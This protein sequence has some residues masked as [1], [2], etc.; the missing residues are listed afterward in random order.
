MTSGTGD[1]KKKVK[2]A[3]TTARSMAHVKIPRPP[4]DRENINLARWGPPDL[5]RGG[6]GDWRSD[7]LTNG[8]TPRRRRTA[9]AGGA[10][11]NARHHCEPL[12]ASHDEA[13]TR[14]RRLDLQAPGH[15]GAPHPPHLSDDLASVVRSCSLT[16][17]PSQGVAVR[18]RLWTLQRNAANGK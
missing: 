9:E 7:W 12:A 10:S 13:L 1:A 14:R 4:D 11:H 5:A 6:C 15:R 17:P 16:A 3:S 2:K 8:G 18:T